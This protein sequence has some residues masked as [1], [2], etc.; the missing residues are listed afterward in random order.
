VHNCWQL[1]CYVLFYYVLNLFILTLICMLL[2]RSLKKKGNTLHLFSGAWVYLSFSFH[3]MHVEWGH[4]VSFSDH[5]M[6][7]W[8]LYLQTGT[9][10]SS[11]L[12]GTCF[13]CL[14]SLRR[15]F[16]I[17]YFHFVSFQFGC[18]GRQF[19]PSTRVNAGN[20]KPF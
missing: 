9:R 1:I 19:T 12:S 13:F 17:F 4:S 11:F 10:S 8:T 20:H 18:H 7:V 16:S 3:V 2:G 6:F 14:F 15:L 5:E